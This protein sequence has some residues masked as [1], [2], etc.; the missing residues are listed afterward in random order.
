MNEVA[1]NKDDDEDDYVDT[2]GHEDDE[3]EDKREPTYTI[4]YAPPKE[5]VGIIKIE[6]LEYSLAHLESSL[7]VYL[8]DNSEKE[9]SNDKTAFKEAFST[10][11]VETYI[12][13]EKNSTDKSGWSTT[14]ETSKW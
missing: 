6:P 14:K 12:A 7:L 8:N 3:D 5:M 13:E 1:D 11:D 2:A 10:T 4:Q 9:E